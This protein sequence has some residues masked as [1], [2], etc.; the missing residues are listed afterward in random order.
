MKSEI[1]I[2]LEHI[3]VTNLV[4]EADF[5][6]KAQE[7]LPEILVKIGEETGKII[8]D[9]MQKS[10]KNVRGFKVNN[11]LGDKNRFI[12]EKGQEYRKNMK[13]NETLVIEKQ[14]IDKLK[15]KKESLL[16]QQEDFIRKPKMPYQATVY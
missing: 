3:N 7:I 2:D 11:S 10:F 4:T 12:R 16:N 8:W 14:I 1:R 15:L 5:K 6:R 13:Q 9:G